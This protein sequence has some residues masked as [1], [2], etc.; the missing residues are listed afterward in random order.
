MV[1]IDDRVVCA[2]SSLVLQSPSFDRAWAGALPPE[3]GQP[4]DD[5]SNRLRHR[6]GESAGENAA[7]SVDRL[8]ADD[9]QN[10]HERDLIRIRVGLLGRFIDQ[11]SYRIVREQQGTAFLFDQLR[12]S[13]QPRPTHQ[14]SL[15]LIQ[16]HLDLPPPVVARSEFGGGNGFVIEDR[17]DQPDRLGLSAGMIRL[18]SVW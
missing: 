5:L 15:D 13:Q 6:V 14:V 8:A 3:R 12:R 1:V 2:F 9:P 18:G 11:V 16:G 4:L 7:W 17:G 10:A